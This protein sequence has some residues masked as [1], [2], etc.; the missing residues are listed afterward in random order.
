LFHLFSVLEGVSKEVISDQESKLLGLIRND[1]EARKTLDFI[2]SDARLRKA[3]DTAKIAHA[4]QE[5]SFG[6]HSQPYIFHI[7]DVVSFL[8]QSGIKDK[9]KYIV[10]ILHDSLEEQKLTVAEVVQLFGK[11]VAKYV[12]Q[13]NLVNDTDDDFYAKKIVQPTHE[14][15]RDVKLADR[16]SKLKFFHGLRGG[17]EPEAKAELI[18]EYDQLKKETGKHYNHWFDKGTNMGLRKQY[19]LYMMQNHSDDASPV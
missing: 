14:F 12:S 6:K 1:S 16:V 5:R 8:R 17:F 4:G 2:N 10:A 19:A 7:I 3:Y 13:V 15:I 11:D 18:S 9:N